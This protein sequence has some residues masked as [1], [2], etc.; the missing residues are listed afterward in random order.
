[1]ILPFPTPEQR[2]L[3]LWAK[4]LVKIREMKKEIS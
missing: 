2:D 4:K 3:I 1:M